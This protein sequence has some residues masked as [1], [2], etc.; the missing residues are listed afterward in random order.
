MK[1]QIPVVWI[2]EKPSAAKDLAAGLCLA[3]RAQ[4]KIQD[5]Y[6]EL[7]TG[8][9][10]LP[11]AGHL[12]ET[13]KPAEYLDAGKAKI[14]RSNDFDRYQEILPIFPRKLKKVPRCESSQAAKPSSKARSS[15]A[16]PKS[17]RN[18]APAPI[19]PYQVAS[20]I[21]PR[22]KRIINAGDID[23]EGQLI[24]DE[25]LEHLGIDPYGERVMRFGMAS[26]LAEDIAR[27]VKANDFKRNGD[28]YWRQA[29]EA[30]ATRQ[31][32][33]WT[34][35][36]NLSMM[37]QAL[38]RNPRI[39]AG[40]VQTP[41]LALVDERC[42]TI[43]NFKPVDYYVP[44]IVLE[45]GTLMRWTARPGS[46]GQPGFDAQGRIIDEA[47]A[48]A[49]VDRIRRGLPGEITRASVT[50]HKQKP[51]LGYSLSLLQSSAARETGATLEQAGEAAKALYQV[52][53]A[54]SYIGTDC[55]YLPESMHAQA[56]GLL[57]ALA[58][59]AAKMTK[60][61][62]TSLRSPIFND[63]KLDEHYAIVPTGKIPSGTS[64]LER[65]VYMMV[66]RRFIAQFYPDYV[67]RKH[68]LEA[69]FGED[70]FAASQRQDVHLGW[71][72]VDG[73]SVPAPDSEEDAPFEADGQADAGQM[74]ERS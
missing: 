54:I 56:P 40:R 8:D 57:T 11:L 51:P 7:S 16:K 26:N 32:V 17:Q 43:E 5:G 29:S 18:P 31:H 68:R 39:S 64:E 49:I 55:R 44:V 30:A 33:D 73:Q 4:S 50:E 1:D 6:I 67:Y 58:E 72:E 60:G 41:V 10:I 65:H 66:V 19:R 46:E 38:H 61:A 28:P 70:H 34:W 69:K 62:D 35:G 15:A 59:V 12:L 71:R 9:I 48:L 27:A 22:A 74:R 20:K 42:R 53:K 63:K 13:V 3:Y 14:E 45:D 47:L 36:I 23:R 52:H 24:V 21:L 25:L 2:A 37:G